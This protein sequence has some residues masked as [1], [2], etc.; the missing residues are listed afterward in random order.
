MAKPTDSKP[1]TGGSNPSPPAYPPIYIIWR[2][3]D[4]GIFYS[5]VIHKDGKLVYQYI[6]DDDDIAYEDWEWTTSTRG[7]IE[8]LLEDLSV[9]L[10][11]MDIY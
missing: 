5:R 1:V 3:K 11:D 8:N 2:A 10:Y 4:K 7:I 9:H 6:V